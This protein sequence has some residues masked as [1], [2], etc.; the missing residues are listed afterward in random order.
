MAWREVDQLPA[1]RS[2][3]VRPPTAVRGSSGSGLTWEV[4]M[5][6]SRHLLAFFGID[7]AISWA[8]GIELLLRDVLAEQRDIRRLMAQSNQELQ[9]ALAGS[10]D[11]IIDSISNVGADVRDLQSKL[12]EA[13]KTAA[14]EAELRTIV[15]SHIASLGQVAASAEAAAGLY[16]RAE[17]TTG[18]GTEATA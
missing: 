10:T 8:R 6:E 11:R 16:K 18:T 14:S 15:E 12:A 7:I 5:F 1:L 13:L 4:Q 2:E 9:A 17:E 3:P